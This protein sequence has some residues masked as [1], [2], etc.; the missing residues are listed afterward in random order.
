MALKRKKMKNE[1]LSLDEHIDYTTAMLHLWPHP[2]TKK[3][4]DIFLEKRASEYPRSTKI[5]R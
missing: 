5:V 2:E 1:P 3:T 4:L